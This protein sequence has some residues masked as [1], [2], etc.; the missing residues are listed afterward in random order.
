ME[1]E[2]FCGNRSALVRWVTNEESKKRKKINR[3]RERER[4]LVR[5]LIV[6]RVFE[7]IVGILR[8]RHYDVAGSSKRRQLKDSEN[9]GH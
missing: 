1:N 9:E 7:E 4:K 6:E 3:Q 5:S 8:G 2:R